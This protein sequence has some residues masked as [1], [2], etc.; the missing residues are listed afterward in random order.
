MSYKE[1]ILLKKKYMETEVYNN[2][3]SKNISVNINQEE[4][5]IN[6][7]N[8]P[9]DDKIKIRSKSK[10]EKVRKYNFQDDTDNY[11]ELNNYEEKVKERKKLLNTNLDERGNE[12]LN[13]N[14]FKY[15]KNEY[16]S[17]RKTFTG[18]FF[19]KKGSQQK[20]IKRETF[21][22]FNNK[23]NNNNGLNF[24]NHAYKSYY[25]GFKNNIINKKQN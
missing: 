17:M 13:E 1:Y 7:K 5:K 19:Q 8:N 25:G 6:I 23:F 2:N 15:R 3:N 21:Y 11:T 24:N 4:R 20:D 12:V 16:K 18:K 10:S 9:K 14:L 22:N